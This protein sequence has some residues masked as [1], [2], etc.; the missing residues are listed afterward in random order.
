M[1]LVGVAEGA[2]PVSWKYPSQPSGA[3]GEHEH[4]PLPDPPPPE[5]PA[6]LLDATVVLPPLT[7]FPPGHA[8]A[9]DQLTSAGAEREQDE[10]RCAGRPCGRHVT[11][12][13][14][15]RAIVLCHDRES[16]GTASAR[17]N[18]IGYPPP[19]GRKLPI[20]P[21]AASVEATRKRLG[22]RGAT[23]PGAGELIRVRTVHGL[24]KDAVVLFVRGDELDVWI[25]ED[26]VLRT[27]RFRARPASGT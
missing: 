1:H 14:A 12:T 22:G 17:P 19:M 26:I 24:D 13:P 11:R 25:A 9:E 23:E 18:D 27:R 20:R 3:A 8:G 2:L 16:I 21:A 10:R 4:P 5:A 15:H 6:P 7:P